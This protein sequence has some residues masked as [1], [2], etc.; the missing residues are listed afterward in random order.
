MKINGLDHINI[1]TRDLDGSARFYVNVFGL[2][3]ETTPTLPRDR[4]LWLCDHAGK[5]ILH[6]FIGDANREGTTG[7]IH[8]VALDCSGFE[9][10]CARLRAHDLKPDI[11]ENP[12]QSF[13]QVFVADP[14]G[15][16]WELI[17]H[18]EGQG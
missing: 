18:G 9:D 13:R 1:R 4:A 8:H 7:P 6:L 11:R 10:M 5:P 17:F 12:D 2:T 14:F 15:V 3:A 16:L